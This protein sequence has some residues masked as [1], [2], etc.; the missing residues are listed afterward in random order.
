MHVS[1]DLRDLRKLGQLVV[2]LDVPHGWNPDTG[3]SGHTY[4]PSMLISLSSPKKCAANQK[5]IE[6]LEDHYLAKRYVPLEFLEKY[7]CHP[8]KS[9][10]A[11]GEDQ[12]V[13]LGIQ[14]HY[15]N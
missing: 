13:K 1:E 9:V 2:A 5:V 12:F 10:N 6:K 14:S 11:L 15:N 7:K 8:P 3:P 4:Y